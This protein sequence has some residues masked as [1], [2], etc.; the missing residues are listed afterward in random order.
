MCG[1]LCYNI[2]HLT[3]VLLTLLLAVG[4]VNLILVQDFRVGKTR[5][6]LGGKDLYFLGPSDH[7]VGRLI[8]G[9]IV[10]FQQ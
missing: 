2:G 5:K 10:V 3:F 8:S 4:V 7:G 9:K 6:R 1:T